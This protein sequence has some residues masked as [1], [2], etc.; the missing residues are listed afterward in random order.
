MKWK[1]LNCKEAEAENNLFYFYAR[2]EAEI[3]ILDIF[4]NSKKLEYIE[5]FE[6]DNL[7]DLEF[8][9]LNYIEYIK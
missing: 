4:R 2:E 7:K 5:S 3:W 6:Y 9:A 1:K 8:D